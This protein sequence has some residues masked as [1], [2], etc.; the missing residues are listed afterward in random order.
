[1]TELSSESRR[2]AGRQARQRFTIHTPLIRMSKRE[3]L[4]VGL[5]L[6]VDYGLTISCYDPHDKRRA[7]GSCD[8]CR[9]R[10]NAF[11]ALGMSDPGKYR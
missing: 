6:G 9:L 1:M 7:C 5:S 8:A 4:G 10:L 2:K 11:A 3:I